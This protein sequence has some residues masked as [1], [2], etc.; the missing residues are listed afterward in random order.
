[1]TLSKA[2]AKGSW[3]VASRSACSR[4]KVPALDP[5][6]SM[7]MNSS[8]TPRTMVRADQQSP[9]SR[10]LPMAWDMGSLSA[11]EFMMTWPKP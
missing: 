2:R 5:S 3:S 1:M 6:T 10:A 7:P 4:V 8:C 11:L 9:A